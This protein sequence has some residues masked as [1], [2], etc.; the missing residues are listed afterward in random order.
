MVDF[1]RQWTL[2]PGQAPGPAARPAA[3]GDRGGGE[4]GS[5]GAGGHRRAA[6]GLALSGGGFRAMLF[7][8]GALRRL[9]ELDAL[10]H[11]DRISSV[12]GGS[13][14]AAQLALHWD[15]IH[16]GSPDVALFRAHVEQP[17]IEFASSKLDLVAGVAGL[18]AP[19]SSIA[20]RAAAAFRELFNGATLQQLPER[21]RFVFCATNLGSGSLVRFARPYTADRR[22]GKRD[23]LDLDLGTVVAASAAFPPFLSPMVIDLDDSQALTEQFP[24]APHEEPPELAGQHAYT[25]RLQLTDGG[26]YDNLGLQPIEQYHTLLVS[27][28]GGAFTFDPA[29][30][31]DWLMHMVRCWH[32]TDNQV[33]SLRRA[34]LVEDLIQDRRNGAFWAIRTDYGSY[35]HRSLP[36]DAGWA[37]RLQGVSTR[38]W[39]MP[40]ETRKRLINWS[41]CLADA[42]LRTYVS[43][44]IEP[45]PGLP[46]PEAP[47]DTAPPPSRPSLL[48]RAR[49]FVHRP[50]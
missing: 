23:G 44:A 31:T 1:A 41:Y 42:A 10:R 17:L 27:D 24:V 33:R 13:I 49:A 16:A 15:D 2:V 45:P 6:A 46:Y 50:S 39:P 5:D 32:V 37:D 3:A 34:S 47:L 43:P 35:Q 14:T 7:H 36:V 18:L 20:D 12:S 9:Y 29:V 4:A 48:D 21:P 25:H 22:I 28:G 40:M 8:I 38:L 30:A 26:V 11:V 19:R